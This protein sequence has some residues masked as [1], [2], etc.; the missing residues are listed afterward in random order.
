MI[1]P[2]LGTVQLG[3]PYGN[4]KNKE[5]MP[6]EDASAI[7]D[8]ALKL[9]IRFF[10]TAHG[11]GKS[12]DRIGR[13]QSAHKTPDLVVSS[14]IPVFTKEVWLSPKAL[15]DVVFKSAKESL[16]RL[17][18]KTFDLL[19]FHQCDLDFLQSPSTA[20][21]MAN[22]IDQGI[23][24]SVGVSV[25]NLEQAGAALEIPA[26]SALQIPINLLDRRFAQ[27]KWLK[28]FGDRKVRLIARSIFLQG[29]LVDQA[30]L[31]QV[32]KTP[33]LK[34]LKSLALST[35]QRL[36]QSLS[37]L[38]L[39]YI[40]GNL[41]DDLSIGLLGTDSV[42][43]LQENI[44]RLKGGP[45]GRLEPLSSEELKAFTEAENFSIKNGLYNPATWD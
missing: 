6:E 20:G 37:T 24:S 43:S 45:H 28:K 23:C 19:Q 13:S 9:G 18:L 25:Y 2:G 29:V 3:L 39:R 7:L 5:L 44:E 42:Q 33:E 17:N 12:E 35:A 40:F 22:L 16:T 21:V 4:A 32:R 10:D 30:E 38:A 15:Q 27:E 11:Y 14:K 34:I 8:T 26:V 41:K 1:A 36:E 31:P